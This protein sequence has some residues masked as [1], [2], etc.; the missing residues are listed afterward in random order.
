MIVEITDPDPSTSLPLREGTPGRDSRFRDYRPGSVHV[1][2]APRRNSGKGFRFLPGSSRRRGEGPPGRLKPPPREGSSRPAPVHVAPAPRRTSG[3]VK[4]PPLAPRGNSGK[5]FRFLPGSSRRRGEGPPGRLKP[6]PPNRTPPSTSLPL[7]EG[8]P[9]RSSR[10]KPPHTHSRSAKD[11]REGQ[12]AARAPRR[13]SGKVKPPPA[14]ANDPK[15]EFRISKRQIKQ[16]NPFKPPPKRAGKATRHETPPPSQ[17]DCRAAA[18]P[19]APRQSHGS[20][21]T[22]IQSPD[23]APWS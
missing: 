8:P 2:P 14:P 20:P 16:N 15:S 22:P 4:P 12:A 13:T 10:R 23:P 11:L 1:A 3:K 9:G 17:T 21:P 5:G 19:R 7:R 18:P 6:P